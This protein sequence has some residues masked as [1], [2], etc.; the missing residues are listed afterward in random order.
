MFLILSFMGFLLQNWRTGENRSWGRECWYQWEGGGSRES[1]RWVIMMQIM[2]TYVWK[3]KIIP[4]EIAPV[5][6]GREE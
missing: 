6:G 4:V 5:K 2:C 1:V 3:C